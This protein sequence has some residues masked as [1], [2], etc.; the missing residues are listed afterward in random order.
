MNIIVNAQHA[1]YDNTGRPLYPNYEYTVSKG[2]WCEDYIATGI[3]SV[4][5]EAEIPVVEE[6][7]EASPK[8]ST[9]NKTTRSQETVT[10]NTEENSNG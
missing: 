8:K 5:P 4:M 1:I 10:D 9:S 2:Q 3:F 7:V 6:P